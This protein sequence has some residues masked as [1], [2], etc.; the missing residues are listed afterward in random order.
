[1]KLIHEL[2]AYTPEGIGFTS[3]AH[4]LDA[5]QHQ[6]KESGTLTYAS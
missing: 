6:T 5:M 4:K 3:I 1:M 2:Y